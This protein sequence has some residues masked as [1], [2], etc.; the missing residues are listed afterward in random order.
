MYIFNK[1]E[2]ALDGNC[3]FLS[4]EYL[5]LIHIWHAVSIDGQELN[6]RKMGIILKIGQESHCIAKND[7]GSA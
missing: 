1:V 6:G 3:N 2:R 7:G 4:N 5:P